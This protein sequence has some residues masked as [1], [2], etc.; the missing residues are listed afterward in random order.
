M[1]P[2]Y[3]GN[4]TPVRTGSFSLPK[5][6]APEVHP[7][8]RSGRGQPD[9][10]V[11]A[12]S[13]SRYYVEANVVGLSG[14]M[15]SDPLEDEIL[16]A[17]DEL[18]ASMPTRT[19]LI[20][21]SCGTLRE[22]PPIRRNVEE[23]RRW[24]ETVDREFPG[25][26]AI[27]AQP[28]FTIRHGEWALTLKAYWRGDRDS[29]R[30]IA[31]GPS[32]GGASTEDLALRDNILDRAKRY[33]ELDHPLII[34][35]NTMSGVQGRDEEMAALFGREQVTWRVDASGDAVTLPQPS[36]E[37]D[38]VWRNRSGNRYSRLHGVLFFRAARPWNAD[39]V[40]SHLYVNPYIDADIPDELLQLG[41]ARVRDG[42]MVWEDGLRL[43]DLLDLP[44][45][46][47]SERTPPR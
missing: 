38:S 42:Q 9:F 30:L 18:A 35:M 19:A 13:G 3:R 15:A 6:L 10:R 2:T 20:A 41:S 45:G 11:W 28:R 17:I 4:G 32:K 1:Q 44:V 24:L 5:Q 36:R 21:D 23:L 25:E 31:I 14:F 33:G 7:E 39:E 12:S 22:P 43:G 34:A 46:W 26:G 27:E 29:S 37:P 47:P 8:P 40:V 16:D